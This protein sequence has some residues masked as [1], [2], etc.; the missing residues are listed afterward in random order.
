MTAG[1]DP[2]RSSA[3]GLAGAVRAGEWS[4]ADLVD[5]HIARIEEVNPSLNAMVTPMFDEARD[6]AKSADRRI[7]DRGSGDLPPLF[8]VPVTVKDCWPVEG[9]RFTAGSWFMRDNV[10]DEDAEI[11]TRLRKAGAI[12]LGKTNLPDMSW[13]F[14]T[15]NPIFGR[16]ENPRAPGHTAGGS[17][18]GEGALIAAGGSPLGFGSDIGGSLRNPAA[19]NGCVSLKPT[20]GRIP[21]GGHVPIVDEAVRGFNVAGP[22][23]RRVED[24]NLALSVLSGEP[25]AD[26]PPIDG[27]RC[28]VNLR[29]G[30]IPVRREVKET[31]LLAA[32]ALGASGMRVDRD[33]SLP[34]DR[35]GFIYTA[36]LRGHAL[37]GIRRDLGGGSDY[38]A[39][40]ELL[41]GLTGKAR[42]SREALTVEG[43]IRLGGRL[44]PLLGEGGFERLE[45]HKVEVLGV[46]G[47]GVLLCPLL[48]TRP[49]RHGATYRPLTQIPYASPFNATGM[50]AA[51]V[52]VRWTDDGLPLAVQVVAREGADELVLAVAAELERAF[53]GWH[54]E[55]MASTRKAT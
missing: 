42:I 22:L 17:S 32:G 54:I 27:V 41:R 43:Y 45:R 31:V 8:G 6:Q 34:L 1:I 55:E 53:G 15:V 4:V 5:A 12:I 7:A 19:N 33:D 36:L 13:G 3:T 25:L 35:L 2:L 24:L 44:G 21:A 18:G 29:N 23:A 16:T 39:F 28:V 11:V 20:S 48:M 37:A 46:I 52:P 30:P 40:R 51:V 26:L 49:P 47:E 38:G 14:E 10:A 9:V 50:P